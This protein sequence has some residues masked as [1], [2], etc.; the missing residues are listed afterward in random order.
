LT[1][2]RDDSKNFLNYVIRRF[3]LSSAPLNK[4]QGLDLGWDTVYRDFQIQLEPRVSR[5]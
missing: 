5:K 4:P 1:D 3:N 2:C